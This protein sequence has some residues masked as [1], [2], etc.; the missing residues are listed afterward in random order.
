[1]SSADLRG[2]LRAALQFQPTYRDRKKT[3]QLPAPYL[4]R[5]SVTE[6]KGT[7]ATSRRLA[8]CSPWRRRGQTATLSAA[9]SR[10]MER[11][12]LDSD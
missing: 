12:P 2:S 10:A 7:T 11:M 6:H 4:D 9:T 5:I 1:M 3:S 8:Q